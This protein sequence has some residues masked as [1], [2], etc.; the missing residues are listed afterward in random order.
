M[1]TH[2]D[3]EAQVE[4]LRRWWKENW[5][6]LA[7]GLVAGLALIF[8]YEAYTQSQDNRR[9]EASQLFEELKT[10]VAAKKVEDAGKIGD[11][12]IADF[13]ATPYA[14]AGAL[15]LAQLASDDSKLEEARKHF[16]W[17]RSNLE[18]RLASPAPIRWIK[19]TLLRHAQPDAALLP[20]IQLRL[21]RVTWQQ[22]KAPEALKLLDGDA[23]TYAVLFDELRG[24]IKLA[25]GDRAAA[26]AEYTKALGALGTAT[27]GTPN[28]PIAEAL[29]RKVDDLADVATAAPAA[30]AAVTP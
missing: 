17:A 24:D 28:A 16:E 22:G 11:R 19:E 12:L 23:G 29:Q 27:A 25:E 26:L 18:S 20:L 14:V 1:S 15:K 4:D 6:P 30:A 21:A 5:I 3:D 13:D 8:S 9:A 2:Y 10:A 7:I